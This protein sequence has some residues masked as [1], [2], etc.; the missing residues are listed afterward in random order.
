M[1]LCVVTLPALLA[2]LGFAAADCTFRTSRDELGVALTAAEAAY[3]TLDVA[4]FQRATTDVDFVVPCLDALVSTD[5]AASLHRIRGLGRFADGDPDGALVAL[6]AARV[7]QPDYV[8]PEEVL[9][10]GFE[11]RTLYEELDPTP[12]EG[13]KLPKPRGGS[14][15][16]DGR[17]GRFRP[18]DTD[19]L[20][21]RTDRGGTVVE[22]RVLAPSDPTP[23]YPGVR[24]RQTAF[25]AS[26]GVTAVGA[27]VLYGLAWSSRGTLDDL[28]AS[29][30]E[31]DLLAVQR[32]TN[33]LFGA[34]IAVGALA[35]GQGVLGLA[36]SEP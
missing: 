1:C 8:F 16:F 25:L 30:T 20:Y 11:L 12:G 35:V 14:L 13:R 7:L 23:S 6:R 31:D 5:L 36:W 10:P 27:G 34:S 21:Q 4:E 17:D 32:R 33:S 22:T 2:S 26:A 18:D 9:P 15:V 29:W 19:A 3:V 28:D 24:K